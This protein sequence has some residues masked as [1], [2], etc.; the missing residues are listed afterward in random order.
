MMHRLFNLC[1]RGAGM[2][3][4]FLLIFFLARILPPEEVGIYGLF[5][6]TV[7]Y[8]L[9]LLGL[10]FYTYSGR[11]MLHD[12]K[13]MWPAML[14]DQAV[15]FACSYLVVFPLLGLV[16]IAGLLPDKYA[17]AFYILLILEHL[18]Q[19]LNRL[20]VIINKPLAAGAFSFI[21]SGAWCYALVAV[22]LYG[23]IKVD[24]QIVLWQWALADTLVLISGIWMLRKLPWAN[25]TWRINWTW[26]YEGLK[27]AVPFLFGTLALRGLFTLDRYFIETFSGREIL[28]VYTLYTGICFSLI[29]F[30]DAAVFSFRYP[31]LVSLYKSGK[32]AAFNAAKRDFVR[33]TLVVVIL[34]TL[35]MGLSIVPVLQW[36][37]K[38][39]YQQHLPVFFV[40]L[41]A[42]AVFVISHIPHYTLYAMGQDRSIVGAHIAGFFVFIVFSELLVQSYMMGMVGVAIALLVAIVVMWVLKQWKIFC[43][44]KSNVVRSSS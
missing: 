41:A 38:P 42:S 25:M 23:L 40:L 4:K 27:V 8:A 33:Q 7:S 17:L 22:Y 35:A 26:I 29:G 21:R 1:M 11:G 30:V 9:Y 15:L 6:V 16:F 24:L 12:E 43:L 32:R 10:D 19:E 39:I 5:T 44:H 34:L 2:V 3:G 36:I 18:S 14:R 28:G 13:K 20:M 31:I 37:N